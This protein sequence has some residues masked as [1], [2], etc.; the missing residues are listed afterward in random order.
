MDTI[1][2]MSEEEPSSK[3]DIAEIRGQATEYLRRRGNKALYASIS[4]VLGC[5]AITLFLDGFP[6]HAYWESFGK[7]LIFL[8]MG[9]LIVMLNY[10]G[11]FWSAWVYRR[12][13]EKEFA[14]DKSE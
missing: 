1:Y 8:T 3:K 13:I 14:S 2:D 11:M 6:L 7:Y 12:D 10:V 9:L 4:F 5:A